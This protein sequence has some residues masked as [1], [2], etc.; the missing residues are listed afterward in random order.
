LPPYSTPT[1]NVN[2]QPRIDASGCCTSDLRPPRLKEENSELKQTNRRLNQ[3]V[4]ILLSEFQCQTKAQNGLEPGT[5]TPSRP[6]NESLVAS[7]HQ[8]SNVGPVETQG[9]QS[10]MAGAPIKKW[11]E[12]QLS[13]TQRRASMNV[14]AAATKSHVART[15]S[16]P[17]SPTR[18]QQFVTTLEQHVERILAVEAIDR[19]LEPL[20]RAQDGVNLLTPPR[21]KDD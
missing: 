5:E 1:L 15:R 20:N 21:V 17:A 14:T 3:Q 8:A 11:Q 16:S 7:F 18:P 6:H 10:T 4:Q 19:H 13:A 9:G 2:P 12:R